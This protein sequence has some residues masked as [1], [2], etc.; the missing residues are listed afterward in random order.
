MVANVLN[1]P[2]AI[3]MSVAVI[4]AFVQQRRLVLSIDELSNKVNALEKGFQAH[5]QRFE[6]VFD[7]IRE[8]MTPPPDPPRKKIGFH[9]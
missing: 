9:P 8:L 2:Q 4:K 5:G 7:A 1:S 3:T 6:M